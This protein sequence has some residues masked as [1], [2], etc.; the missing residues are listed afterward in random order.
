M[1]LDLS[2]AS[3]LLEPFGFKLNDK[4][5]TH[6]NNSETIYYQAKFVI[7]TWLNG[8]TYKERAATQ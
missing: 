6:R 3:A 7:L 4:F 8:T 5:I 2:V 1:K